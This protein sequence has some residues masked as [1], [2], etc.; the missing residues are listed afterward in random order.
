MAQQSKLWGRNG[1][2]KISMVCVQTCW[3]QSSQV[4]GTGCLCIRHECTEWQACEGSPCMLYWND[5]YLN[6]LYMQTFSIIICSEHCFASR[7]VGEASVLTH[8]L[9]RQNRRATGVMKVK[10]VS[11]ILWFISRNRYGHNYQQDKDNRNCHF[12][13]CLCCWSLQLQRSMPGPGWWGKRQNGF[14]PWTCRHP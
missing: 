8:L 3:C 12:S 1:V 14:A 5:A 11:N 9:R 10:T 13:H 2:K 6:L 4:F 7:P